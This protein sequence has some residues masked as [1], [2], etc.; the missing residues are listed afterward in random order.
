[1]P[2]IDLKGLVGLEEDTYLWKLVVKPNS[3]DGKAFEFCKNNSILGVGWCLR[4]AND[5]LYI[6]KDVD[7]AKRSG[8]EY[9]DSKGFVTAINAMKEIEPNDL[10]WTRYEGI[11]YI[12]R[13]LSKWKYSNRPENIK[14]DICHY[15]E[16]EFV[17]VGTIEK[18]LGR[19][20]N[21]FR[22]RSAIQ[23]IHDDNKI[24][25]NLT[26]ALYNELT[27]QKIYETNTY[28]KEDLFDLLQAEDVEEVISLYL[29]IV[30]NYLVYT[31][32]NK[33]DTQKYEFVA[34]ARDGSHLCYPQVKTGGVSLDGNDYLDLVKGGNKVV[35]FATSEKY[36]NINDNNIIAMYKKDLL[37]F[38]YANKKVMPYRIRQWM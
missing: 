32:T 30:E 4:D 5:N 31:S 9:Y 37:D 13:V 16:V 28:K 18:V 2:E 6:P 38:V 21:C 27:G 8:I 20:T 35:L 29:Q 25:T 10:I 22:A 11:Y 7:D 17:E 36:A 12:C 1:M 24:M 15:V 3:K 19:I 33:L 23:R 14:E 26:K 34:I